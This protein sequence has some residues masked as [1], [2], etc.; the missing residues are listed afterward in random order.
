MIP[1]IMLVYSMN[2]ILEQIENIGIVPVVAIQNAYD[3][4][5]LGGALCRGGLPCAEIT[6]RTEAAEEAIRIM[7]SEYP[8]M[9]VGAGTVLT[10]DQVDRARNAGAKFIVSPG[11]NPKVVQYCMEQ[12]IPVTPGCTNPSDIEQAIELGLDVVKIFPAEAIG[13]LKMIKAMSAPYGKIKFMPTGGI[14]EKNLRSYLDFK[15]IIACGGSWMVKPELIAAGDFDTIEKLTRTAVQNMLGFELRHIGINEECE[16]TANATADI[17]QSMF[18]FEKKEGKASY[19]VG[20]GFEIMKSPG[21]GKHGHIAIQTN[22]MKRAIYHLEMQGLEFNK[23]NVTK[24][25]NGD[26][27]VIFIKSEVSGFGVHLVQK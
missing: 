4:K 15:K 11:L 8:E 16:D 3:A 17:F 27:T 6:F 25:E 14:D 22:D 9:L 13:G 10:I 20:N 1:D 21:V 19:F 2:Q 7:A 5:S 12:K 24:N 26:I 23:E 18:G